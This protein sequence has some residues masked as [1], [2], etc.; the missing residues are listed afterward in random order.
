MNDVTKLHLTLKYERGNDFNDQ[1]NHAYKLSF[2]FAEYY[3]EC[4]QS[5]M[6]N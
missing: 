1:T 3:L 6:S 4:I 5:E 2:W